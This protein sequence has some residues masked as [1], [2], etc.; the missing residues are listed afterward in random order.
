[1]TDPRTEEIMQ[2][3][4]T[5]CSNLIKYDNNKHAMLALYKKWKKHNEI[6]VTK[7]KWT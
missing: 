7:K 6:L 2:N 3:N 1:M 5:A 4:R